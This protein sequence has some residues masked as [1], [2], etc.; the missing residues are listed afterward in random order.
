M[1]PWFDEGTRRKIYILGKDPGATLRTLIE[2]QDLPKAYG[3]ELDWKFE[4][5]PALDAPAKE[6]I[7]EMPKGPAVFVDGKVIQPPPGK[8]QPAA[9][10]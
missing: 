7:G 8:R 2:P 4:D 10:A 5:E 1:Q 3:G 6:A 9:T